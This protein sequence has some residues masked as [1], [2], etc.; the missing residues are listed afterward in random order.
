MGV[1]FAASRNRGPALHAA[2]RYRRINFMLIDAAGFRMALGSNIAVTECGVSVAAAGSGSGLPGAAGRASCADSRIP[3]ALA[4]HGDSGRPGAA[5][6]AQ[7]GAFP[8]QATGGC[9]SW[10]LDAS[11][12]IGARV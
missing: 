12:T 9:G 2:I 10:L 6:P 3:A 7:P 11:P 4:H 8:G 1:G 5:D